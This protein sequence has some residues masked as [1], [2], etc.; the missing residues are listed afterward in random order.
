[1]S[2]CKVRKYQDV[3]KSDVKQYKKGQT[4]SEKK[5]RSGQFTNPEHRKKKHNPN[6]RG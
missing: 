6:Y 1:M 2:V 4:H 3:I 5:N